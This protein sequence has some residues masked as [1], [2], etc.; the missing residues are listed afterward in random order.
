MKVFLAQVWRRLT[1]LAHCAALLS[2]P[3]RAHRGQPCTDAAAA[4]A[5]ARL[6]RQLARKYDV[7]VDNN[8]E[9][10]QAVGRVPKNGLPLVLTP[11][12]TA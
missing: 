10:Q 8:T 11:L 6:S 1:V 4:D 9:W 12:T 2:C 5:A 3:P 7:R